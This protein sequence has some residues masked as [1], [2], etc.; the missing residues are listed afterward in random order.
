MSGVVAGVT[1]E[2]FAELLGNSLYGTISGDILNKD[3]KYLLQEFGGLASSIS[4]LFVGKATGLDSK[5]ISNNVYAGYRVRKNAVENNLVQ[6]M[7]KDLEGSL[8]GKHTLIVLD[9]DNPEDFTEEKMLKNGI[10]TDKVNFITLDNGKSVIAVSGQAT[11]MKNGNLIADFNNEY[12]L[13]A[14]NEYYNIGTENDKTKWY[15]IDYDVEV[16]TVNSNLSDT[17][18]IYNILN[19]AQNYKNNTENIIIYEDNSKKTDY[20]NR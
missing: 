4:S 14:I 13:K 18:F 17:D 11:S 10:N 1:G 5:D 16:I 8:F 6:K 3:Q 15:K 2:V 7:S 19:N 12:D 9:P 20:F